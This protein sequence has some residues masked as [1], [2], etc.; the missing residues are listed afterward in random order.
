M[1][2]LITC[3]LVVL[4]MALPCGQAYSISSQAKAPCSGVLVPDDDARACIR[5]K[6]IDLPM[7]A[8]DLDHCIGSRHVENKTS[9]ISIDVLQTHARELES[10]LADALEPKPWYE[11]PILAFTIGALTASAVA[12]T[13]TLTK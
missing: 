1:I 10:L 6:A 13:L 5:L 3:T 8:S 7:C 12:V 4:M 11:D 9:S 2:R